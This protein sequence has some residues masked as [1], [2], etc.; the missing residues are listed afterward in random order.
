M[1]EAVRAP[2][3]PQANQVMQDY[4]FYVL[5]ALVVALLLG[6]LFTTH[7]LPP[8]SLSMACGP[9]GSAFETFGKRYQKLLAQDGITLNLINTAGSAENLSLLAQADSGVEMGFVDGGIAQE[10]DEPG[11]V[12]LGTV[13]YEPLWVFSRH[14]N[15]DRGLSSLQGKRVSV[16][17]D[18]SESAALFDELK[19]RKTLDIG[20]F[21]RVTASTE[22]SAAALLQGKLDAVILVSSYASPVIRKLAADPGI[23]LANFSLADA[24]VAHFPTLSKRNFPEGAADLM[25]DIPKHD[26]TLL[27]TKTSLIIRGDMHPALQYAILQVISQV[28]ARGGIFN[29]PGDFPAAETQ[30]IQL[31]KE[32]RNYYKNGRPIL[33]RYLPFWLAAIVEEILLLIL[34]VLGLTYPIVKG[35]MS[36]YGWG[37]QRK[38][39]SSYGELHYL[40]R[41]LDNLG[42]QAPSKELLARMHR[43]EERCNRMRL[44]TPYIPMLYSLKDSLAGVRARAEALSHRRVART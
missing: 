27:A 42:N 43:L 21:V 44:S 11:L 23:Q 16:G 28:H 8:K 24:F 14:V 35:I 37:M 19:R 20:N 40:E 29:K 3:K 10:S 12:S 17:P 30:E 15:S 13:A 18:G 5:G 4:Q 34:P 33:Q 26:V 9:A 36:L 25:H 6:V 31:G 7:P 41:Q 32:A 1:T 2:K 39:F 22:D 38:I